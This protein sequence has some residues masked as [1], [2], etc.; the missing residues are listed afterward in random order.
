MHS[1]TENTRHLNEKFKTTLLIIYPPKKSHVRRV[2]LVN[3]LVFHEHFHPL[4]SFQL[5]LVFAALSSI[6][7]LHIKGIQLKVQKIQPLTVKITLQM[8][9]LDCESQ[10]KGVFII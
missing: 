6:S 9:I 2:F 7:T 8:R 1:K 5:R 3:S 4:S 10:S